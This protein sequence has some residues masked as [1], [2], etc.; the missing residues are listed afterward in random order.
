V[1]NP[2][3]FASEHEADLARHGPVPEIVVVRLLALV[4]SIT[5]IDLSRFDLDTPLPEDISTNGSLGTLDWL[6]RGNA[7]PRTIAL[8]MG[9]LTET[10]PF[11]GT[12]EQVA[13]EMAET[14]EEVGGDGFLIN[15]P[16]VP[17][18]VGRIVDGLIPALQ[19]K[20]LVRRSYTHATFRKNL[21]S[22]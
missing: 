7:T 8:R 14:M 18:F 16:L 17:G 9:R 10:D 5:G 1:V 6:R 15:G 3:I 19:A 4:S 20:D 22:Y 2:R 13:R 21:L 12:A 11:A